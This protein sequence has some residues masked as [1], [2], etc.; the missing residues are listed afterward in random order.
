MPQQPGI[1]RLPDAHSL[2]ACPLTRKRCLRAVI[3]LLF[4]QPIFRGASCLEHFTPASF[5]SMVLQDPQPADVAWLVRCFSYL[6]LLST[7]LAQQM[8]QALLLLI[9]VP[10][11]AVSVLP[12][13][14]VCAHQRMPN[15]LLPHRW[16]FTPPGHHPAYTLSPC[17]LSCHSLT[18]TT[19]CALARWMPAGEQAVPVRLP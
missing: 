16:S 3:Y 9:A 1:A 5:H 7:R 10:V 15:L 14:S 18:P 12:M 2:L 19:S 6:V 11:L 4:P 8:W 13:L 17:L